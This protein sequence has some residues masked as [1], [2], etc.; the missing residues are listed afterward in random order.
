MK[1]I[2]IFAFIQFKKKL[3]RKQGSAREQD[4]SRWIWTKDPLG[5]FPVRKHR[6]TPLEFLKAKVLNER[7][8]RQL[9]QVALGTGLDE[10]FRTPCR[11]NDFIHQIQYP[12]RPPRVTENFIAIERS[13]FDFL[14]RCRRWQLLVS[15]QRVQ[16]NLK[17]PEPPIAFSSHYSVI[18]AENRHW[19]LSWTVFHYLSSCFFRVNLLTQSLA[20]PRSALDGNILT[21]L[22]R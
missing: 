18:E 3:H 15:G 8:T 19:L 22:D 13:L 2:K 10:E 7:D 14:A 9:L 17:L 20:W 21:I 16:K 11:Y 6:K 1:Q 4:F 5:I 12:Q